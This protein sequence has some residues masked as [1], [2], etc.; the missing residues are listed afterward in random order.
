MSEC[1]FWFWFIR[2]FAE[3]AAVMAIGVPI[4]LAVMIFAYIVNRKKGP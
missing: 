2:P 1:G 3:F 4:I